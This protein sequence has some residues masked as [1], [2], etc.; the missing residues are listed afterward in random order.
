MRDTFF[1]RSIARASRIVFVGG[2]I[3]LQSHGLFGS[4]AGREHDDDI[5]RWRGTEL[6]GHWWRRTRFGRFG[7][8]DEAPVE[9][10][11]PPAA[12]VQAEPRAGGCGRRWWPDVIV[13]AGPRV[14]SS[15]D[16]GARRF[17]DRILL[18][19]RGARQAAR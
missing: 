12:R 13:D 19:P 16:H 8:S 14:G 11:P 15:Q 10:R 17:D 9:I 1:D 5:R 6:D 7:Q 18:L 2:L 4:E 3:G